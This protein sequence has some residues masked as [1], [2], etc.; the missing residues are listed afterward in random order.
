MEM[1][2]VKEYWEPLIFTDGKMDE[3]KVWNELH[4]YRHVLNEVP[5]VYTHITGGRMSKP[6]YFASDVI[7]EHDELCLDKSITQDDV[8]G[9]IRDMTTLDEMVEFLKE[10]FEIDTPAIGPVEE[11]K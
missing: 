11:E 3:V 9:A 6:S 10:Y 4:D 1:S 5:L 8:R 7:S 2:E